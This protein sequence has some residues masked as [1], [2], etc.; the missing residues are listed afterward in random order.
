MAQEPTV[1]G[2]KSLDPTWGPWWKS[3]VADGHSFGSHTFRHGKLTGDLA[4]GRIKYLIN[5]KTELLTKAA[6]CEELR[7]SDTRF[8]ELTGRKLDPFWR[9]PGGHTTPNAIKYAASCGYRHVDWAPAGFLGDELPSD[10]YP[11]SMLL[12]RALANLK[13]GDIIMMHLGIWSRKDPWA[14]ELEPLLTGLEAKGYCFAP[15][16]QKYGK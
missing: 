2:D 12:S 11:N 13:N 9:A 14:P 10:K 15:I 6:F 3:M 8:Q 1:K 5:G 4:D 16:G 7:R